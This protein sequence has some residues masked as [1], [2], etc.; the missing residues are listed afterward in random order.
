MNWYGGGPV[1]ERRVRNNKSGQPRMELY[2]LLVSVRLSSATG[3][4]LPNSLRK[5]QL[6]SYE[7]VASSIP[8]IAE[9]YEFRP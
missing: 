3:K 7:T 1:F 4:P 6:S 9:L 5:I 8:L 2:P